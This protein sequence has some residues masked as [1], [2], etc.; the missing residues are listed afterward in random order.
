MRQIMQTFQMRIGEESYT[1]RIKKLD[2][3]SGAQLLQIMSKYLYRDDI[4]EAG[5]VEDIAMSIFSELPADVMQDIMKTCLHHCEVLLDAGYQPLMQMN[6]WS[7]GE[8]EYDPVN[9]LRL[10]LK[11]ILWTLDGFF[12]ESGSSSPAARPA[13]SQQKQ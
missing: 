3:F 8:L 7:W 13:S 12:V 11:V 5:I 10:T 4:S 2:A 6:E 1:F 9:S